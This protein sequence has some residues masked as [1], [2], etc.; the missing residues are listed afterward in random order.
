[1]TLVL[2][3][4]CLM[5][6]G[7]GGEENDGRYLDASPTAGAPPSIEGVDADVVDSAALTFTATGGAGTITVEHVML[8]SCATSWSGAEVT[9]ESS[10]LVVNY[11]TST[12]DTASPECTWQVRYD[13]VN[14]LP[15]EW[16]VS[17]GGQTATVTVAR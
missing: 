11:D 17:A 9:E 5:P 16:T 4:G 13:I 3:A 6:W 15:G 8:G 2:L 14:V 1:M 12:P 7:M 10:T